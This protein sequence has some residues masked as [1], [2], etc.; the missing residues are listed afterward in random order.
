[1][2][3]NNNLQKLKLVN[4]L[5][6]NT[7]VGQAGFF[8]KNIKHFQCNC[9]SLWSARAGRA[10]PS[11]FQCI[12]LLIKVEQSSW[13]S[14]WWLDSHGACQIK[15]ACFKIKTW[16]KKEDK[17]LS[18]S[19]QCILISSCYHRRPWREKEWH[20]KSLP[21]CCD[22][23]IDRPNFVY[24]WTWFVNASK[25]Q[26]YTLIC[27]RSCRLHWCYWNQSWIF[28]KCCCQVW[29]LNCKS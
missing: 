12:L 4:T 22:S 14:K 18:S 6:V 10:I 20:M 17:I 9:L 2:H 19:W 25:I 29:Q 1:M 13:G 24:W 3:N 21:Q 15:I 28:S 16:T 23:A 8:C 7:K 11:T 5:P 27:K 26:V